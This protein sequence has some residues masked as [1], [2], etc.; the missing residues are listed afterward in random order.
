M[1]SPQDFAPFDLAQALARGQQVAQN[2]Y[3]MKRRRESDTREDEYRSA[4]GD[5][6]TGNGDFGAP[7]KSSAQDRA[8][9]ANPEGY[10]KF[11]GQQTEVTARQLKAHRDLN[12]TAMQLLGGVNDQASYDRARMQAKVLVQRYGGDP[13]M[14]DS[15]PPQYSPELVKSL[16]MQ[17]M[18]THQQLLQVARENKLNWDEYDDQEDNEREDRKV[19]QLGQYRQQRLETQR[20]GQDLVDQR[21]RRGQDMSSSDR[22]AAIQ[23]R[24]EAAKLRGSG[25]AVSAGDGAIIR[26]PKT[27]QRMKLQGGKWVPIG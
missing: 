5:I 23:Q 11:Q 7:D 9:R 8:A 2:D 20:R 16:Q 3:E 19:D 17:G 26:N 4:L 12:D 13:A 14:I 1:P 22:K 21:T 15:L 6:L 10:L 25:K 27:G 18:D 24:R